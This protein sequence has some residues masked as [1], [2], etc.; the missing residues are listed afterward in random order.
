MTVVAKS[1]AVAVALSMSVAYAG[2]TTHKSSMHTPKKLSPQEILDTSPKSAWKHIPQ[3]NLLYMTLAGNKRVIIELADDFAPHHTKQIRT[4]AKSHY[5]DDTAVYRGHDNYV[6]Q[7]GS[8]DYKTDQN[9]KQLPATA[10]KTLPAEF[11]RAIKGL[12]FTALPDKEPYSDKVG[13]VGNFP[14]AVYKGQGFVPHCYG[15]VGVSRDTVDKP[16]TAEDLYVIIGQ[17]ARHLDRQITVAGRVID[18]IEHLSVLPRGLNDPLGFYDNDTDKTAITAIRVGSDLPK[19]E[20]VQFTSLDTQSKTFARWLD[21][22][23]HREKGEWFVADFVPYA[24]VC[25][26]KVPL[27]K[28]P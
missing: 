22:R 21:A 10:Q 9:T 20:Q 19:E 18:G 8:Y 5:W 17:P 16:M 27:K 15:A 2:T 4:L 24:D 23:R 14:V 25:Y 3:D 28:L 12:P 26:T 7:F 11:T 1:I 6:V 13:F